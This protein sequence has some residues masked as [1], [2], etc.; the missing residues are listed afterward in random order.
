MEI[1]PNR[2][3]TMSDAFIMIAGCYLGT[4]VTSGLFTI[5]S[6]YAFWMVAYILFISTRKPVY[7]LIKDLVYKYFNKK[8]ADKCCDEND[9]K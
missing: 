3:T 7:K 8:T 5:L 1:M 2:L 6:T 9:E 4:S